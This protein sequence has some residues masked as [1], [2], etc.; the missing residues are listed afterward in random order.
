MM[1]SK[2]MHDVVLVVLGGGRQ[3][4]LAWFPVTGATVI[5]DVSPS[6]R[7]QGYACSALPTLVIIIIFDILQ[8]VRR[9]KMNRRQHS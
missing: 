7:H 4:P 3:A 2:E 6:V 9:Q 8:C 5:L 1:S